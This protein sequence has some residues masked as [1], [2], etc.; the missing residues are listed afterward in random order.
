MGFAFRFN[1][2]DGKK[3][4]SRASRAGLHFPVG[5]ISRYL[6]RGRLGLRVGSGA[7]VFLAALLEYLAAE[8]LELS[9]NAAHDNKKLRI[10]P[11]HIQLAIRHDDELAKLLGK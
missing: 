3:P 10:I 4:T 6:R 7:P 9:G 11:R 2:Q 5:R 1:Y 8:V